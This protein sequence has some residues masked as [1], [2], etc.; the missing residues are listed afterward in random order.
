MGAVKE[1]AGQVEK[2]EP[3]VPTPPRY[4]IR[5]FDPV[6]Q[7]WCF[8]EMRE[9]VPD[10]SGLDAGFTVEIIDTQPSPATSPQGAVPVEAIIHVLGYIESDYNLDKSPALAA[11]VNTVREFIAAQSA[12][13]QPPAAPSS[14]V[15][16]AL[17]LLDIF[18]ANANA[19]SGP[20]SLQ[21]RDALA[22]LRR[23]VGGE[24]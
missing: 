20:T 8:D 4:I 16:E 22:V 11:W 2:V 9:E 5:T 6:V 10:L 7:E 13:P 17:E 24:R 1:I 15:R 23:Y 12:Q 3:K 19:W 21:A 14:E 18:I